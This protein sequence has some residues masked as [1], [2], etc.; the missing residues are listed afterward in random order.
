MKV[1]GVNDFRPAFVYPDLFIDS[2]T[3]GAVPVTAG[4]IVDL[5]M[6]AFRTLTDAASK[7]PGFAVHDG[8]G[9]FFL[10][11]RLERT[12]TTVI[13]I[14]GVPYLLYLGIIHGGHLPSCQMGFGQS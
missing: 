10:D 6:S 1:G 5:Y 13:R 7:F 11:I 3:I 8:S 9:S 14:R 4:I 12:G 2:L